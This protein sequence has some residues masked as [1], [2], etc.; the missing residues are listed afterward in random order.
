EIGE[1][2][3]HEIRTE[4]IFIDEGLT[5][6]GPAIVLPKERVK[7]SHRHIVPLSKP[8]HAI[9]SSRQ[10]NP[11]KDSVFRR[12]FDDH[13]AHSRAWSRHKKLLDAALAERG[14]KFEH[15]VLHDVRRSVATHMRRD[16]GIQKDT[17]NEVLNHF[18]A[19]VYIKGELEGA[20]RQALAAWGDYL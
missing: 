16:L 18:E 8:A 10:R 15:W 2:K 5:V 4:E 17:I 12:K 1:L 3:W 7:N 20:K 11:D 19:D 6:A 9:L 14:H 13:A